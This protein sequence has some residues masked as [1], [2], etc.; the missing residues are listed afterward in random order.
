MKKILIYGSKDFAKTVRHLVEDCGYETV[1]MI[2]DYSLGDEIIGTFDEVQKKYSSKDYSVVLAI[3]YNNLAARWGIYKKIKE[4]GYDVLTLIH[5]RA[6]VSKSATV[7]EG[8]M[9]M[10]GAVVDVDAIVSEVSVLWP[11]V[12]LNHDSIIGKNVFVSPNAT[13]CGFSKVGDHS[14]IGAGS[15]IVD[16]QQVPDNSFVK[17]NKLFNVKA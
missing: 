10:A 14:F 12:V 16:H 9:V 4:S 15:V 6:Y 5:P 8:S 1:G 13:I 2:D 11:G 7:L 3:G 17:A